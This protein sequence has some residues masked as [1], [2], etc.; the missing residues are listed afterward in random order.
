M[1]KNRQARRAAAAKEKRKVAPAFLPRQQTLSQSRA[2]QAVKAFDEF[3][4]LRDALSSIA[5]ERADW[6]G[7][8][9]PLNDQRLIIE[10]T[11]PKAKE[12]AAIG[13]PPASEDDGWRLRNQWY[14]RRHK[15]DIFLMEKDGKIDWGR[16]PA[17]HHLTQTLQTLG[18][19]DAWGIEQEQRALKLLAGM[20][21]HRAFKQYLLTG[22]FL[23]RSARS[24][25]TYLFRRLKPTVALAARPGLVDRG[26]GMRILASL[27]MHPIAYYA[28]SFAGAMCPTDDVIAHLAMMRGDEHMFWKRCNQHPAHRPEA[29]L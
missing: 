12:L 17:V 7:I 2:L 24:G 1:S 16:L 10:P 11:Y 5:A 27:C 4:H 22:M 18:C 14:S 20:L 25:V 28:N 3:A 6:A 9:M 23:E 15:C 26:G 21:R 19:A 13:A 29:A 8:P